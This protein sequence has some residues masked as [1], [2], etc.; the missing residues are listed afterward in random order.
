[1]STFLPTSRRIVQFSE[2]RAPKPT[3]KVVYVS[4]SWDLFN[5]GHISVR[6]PPCPSA[7]LLP[8]FV[9]ADAI[10]H[11]V[12]GLRCPR[13]CGC[14]CAPRLQFLEKARALGDFLLVGINDDDTVNTEH[15]SGFPIM[16]LHE[17][18]LGCAAPLPTPT[19]TPTPP[20]HVTSMEYIAWLTVVWFAPAPSC[21]VTLQRPAMPLRGRGDHRSPVAPHA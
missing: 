1:M 2:D 7:A 12:A 21:R 18:A 17:R 20:P 16:N 11:V 4:G 6:P 10:G 8:R 3:D 5:A 9:G 15:G 19:L 14:G 13:A